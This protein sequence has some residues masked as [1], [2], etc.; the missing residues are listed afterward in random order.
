MC[1]ALM[2]R[3]HV[4]GHPSKASIGAVNTPR[5][6][7]SR[8]SPWT[9]LGSYEISGSLCTWTCHV[10]IRPEPRGLWSVRWRGEDDHEAVLGPDHLDSLAQLL[11]EE[12]D[13]ERDD[14]LDMFESSGIAAVEEFGRLNKV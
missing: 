9:E 6:S 14:L 12:Y 4:A 10:A 8:P 11:V 5:S 13:L 3:N 1:G 2:T 7:G